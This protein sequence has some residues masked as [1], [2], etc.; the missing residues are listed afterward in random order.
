[1][2]L[3]STVDAATHT[4]SARVSYFSCF[5]LFTESATVTTATKAPISA[6]AVPTTTTA[7]IPA[8][9]G[10]VG[11]GTFPWTTILV[12]CIVVGVVAGGAYYLKKE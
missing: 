7:A 5:A 9:S 12:V 6:T 1:M 2:T 3:T 4:V 11:T 8:A 10:D